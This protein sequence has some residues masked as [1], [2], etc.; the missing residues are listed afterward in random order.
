MTTVLLATDADWIR[1]EVD[2]ALADDDTTVSR[3]RRGVDVL[4]AT[5]AL[6]PD[7]VVLDLQIGSMGGLAACFDLRLE[8]GA[9]RIDPVKILVLLDRADDRFLA[10]HAG[11]DGWMVKPIDGFRMRRAA[12][13]VLDGADW[14]EQAS[15]VVASA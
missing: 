11:A 10:E 2:A 8:E 9:Q 5:A 4:P 14:R 13:A 1:D 7:L 15:G 3:V 12:K 6:H